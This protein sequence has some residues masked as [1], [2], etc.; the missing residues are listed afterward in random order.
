MKKVI[1]VGAG[2]AGSE[3]ALNLADNGFE[4]VLFEMKPNKK[5]PAHKSNGFAELVCS[6]SLKNIDKLTASGL[7]K[8]EL[9]LLGCKLLKLAEKTAV[10]AGGALAVDRDLFSKTVTEEIKN[11]KNITV[12]AE[13]ITSIPQSKDAYV[14]IAT[15]PLT[16]ESLSLDIKKQLNDDGLYFYDASAPIVSSES[17]DMSRAVFMNRYDKGAPDYLNL[18]LNKEEYDAFYEAL[19]TAQTAPLHEFEKVNVYEGCMPIEILAKRGKDAIRFGPMKPVGI[20][21]KEGKT[22]YAVVQLRKENLKQDLYNL[23]GFQ[24]NLKFGE[25]QRVFSLIPALKNAEFVRYGVMHRNTFINSPK[26]LN[27]DLSL[28]TNNKLFFAGQIVGSEGYVE[29]IAGGLFVA[30]Q[31]M[32]RESKKTLIFSNKTLIGSLFNYVTSSVPGDFQPMS[33]NFGLLSPLEEKIKD[34]SIKK[35]KYYLRSVEEIKQILEQIKGA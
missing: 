2:L 12:V 35:E 26:F 32:A 24:T 14:V 25:Q 7:F 27:K 17:I 20:K 3:C 29:S 1:V 10:G 30:L 19:I 9:N 13:E 5:S 23:V 33:V 22:P 11:H 8:E 28:K 4:V 6:N 15:G 34:K 31:I 16:S 21:N 18:D